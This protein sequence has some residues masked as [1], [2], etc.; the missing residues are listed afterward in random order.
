MNCF[1][2]DAFIARLWRFFLWVDKMSVSHH[3]PA[4]TTVEQPAKRQR[5]A[6]QSEGSGAAQRSETLAVHD[7]DLSTIQV[8]RNELASSPAKVFELLI[9]PV[10]LVL[11][12]HP[13]CGG[14]FGLNGEPSADKMFHPRINSTTDKIISVELTG[15]DASSLKILVKECVR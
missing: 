3:S 13:I 9:V 12:N 11:G 7:V 4:M 8:K 14:D 1:V 2:R 6:R 5:T 10:S 15:V